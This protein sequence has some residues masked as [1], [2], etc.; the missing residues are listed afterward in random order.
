[1]VSLRSPSADVYVPDGTLESQAFTRTTD[2]AVGAHQ[3]DLEVMAVAPIAECYEDATRSFT[4]IVC[5]DGAGSPRSGPFAGMPDDRMVELRRQ[6]QQEAA[7]LGRYGAV[8]QLGYSSR[9]LREPGDDAWV[10]DLAEL[11]DACSPATFFTHNLADRHPTHA[12]VAVGVVRAL[13]RL[14]RERRPGRLLGCEAWRGLDW[15]P[16]GERVALSSTGHE[17]LS[18]ALLEVFDSQISGGKRYDLA[19]IGRRRA[20]ATLADSHD[21]DHEEQV[22]LALDMT[23]LIEH[24]DLS[25]VDFVVE[26]VDRFRAEVTDLLARVDPG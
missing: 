15:L 25:P 18:L 14:P 20:N 6:E 10:A 17:S 7:D 2:M 13:R 12:A 19:T 1:V 23:A 11:A 24:D 5:G 16:E 8:V 3:D 22:T 26:L 4:G 9:V 21:V